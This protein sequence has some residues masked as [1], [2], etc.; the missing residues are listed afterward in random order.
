MACWNV[1]IG[2]DFKLIWKSST[3]SCICTAS[4]Y[5]ICPDVSLLS[6]HHQVLSCGPLNMD[7]WGS[8]PGIRYDR[9]DLMLGL[10]LQPCAWEQGE[11]HET[12][13]TVYTSYTHMV[14]TWRME[15]RQPP[16]IK[17]LLH[18]RYCSKCFT[19]INSFSSHK[20]PERGRKYLQSALGK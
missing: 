4:T 5:T 11:I 13:V 1:P 7:L 15:H 19:C 18:V 20:I 8:V 14:G 2:R 6:T 12:M 9:R 17:H 3:N 16:F 10:C